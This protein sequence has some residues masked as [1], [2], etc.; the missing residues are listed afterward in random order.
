[1]IQN[2]AMRRKL[3]SSG[4]MIRAT[5]SPL[6]RSHPHSGTMAG[7]PGISLLKERAHEA[8]RMKDEQLKVLQQQ[9]RKLLGT[10]TDMEEEVADAKHKLAE[11]ETSALKVQDENLQ[12]RTSVQRAEEHGRLEAEKHFQQEVEASQHQLRV[13]AE[14]N[15]E[16]LRLLEAEE[17][18]STTTRTELTEYKHRYKEAVNELSHVRGELDEEIT[19]LKEATKAAQQRERELLAEMESKDMRARG[20]RM[21]IASLEDKLVKVSTSNVELN[22]RLLDQQRETSEKEEFMQTG[23][24]DALIDLRN[25]LNATTTELEIEKRDKSKLKIEVL[26]QADQLKEMAEKVFQLI[27]RLQAA[28]SAKEPA[29]QA[30]V[31]VGLQLRETKERILRLETERAEADKQARRFGEELRRAKNKSNENVK[32]LTEVTK[33]H[34]SEKELRLREARGRQE[35]QEARKALA[36]RVSYL[37][38]KAALDDE[39]R[40]NARVDVKKLE[41]QLHA[42][43]KKNETITAQ[44]RRLNEAN[45]VLT[46]SMRIKGDA[47]EKMQVESTMRNWSNQDKVNKRVNADKKSIAKKGKFGSR[48]NK[49]GAGGGGGGSGGGGGGGGGGGN[50]SMGSVEIAGKGSSLSRGSGYTIIKQL[51][52]GR[53]KGMPGLRASS[54]DDERATVLLK[55]LQINEFFRYIGRRPSEKAMDLCAEKMAQVVGTL[56]MSE[57]IAA[58]RA[59]RAENIMDRLR[60]ELDMLR[61]K[62][63]DQ[64]DRLFSE[65]EAK[66]SALIKYLHSVISGSGHQNGS[67]HDQEAYRQSQLSQQSATR[68]RL[69]GGTGFLD[70]MNS[71]S[72]NLSHFNSSSSSADPSLTNPS[73]GTMSVRPP[74]VTV[75]LGN[76]GIGDEEMH[77][78]VAVLSSKDRADLL[79]LKNNSIGDVGARGL[80]S[81]LRS[82]KVLCEVD[83]RENFIGATGVRILAEAL[84]HNKRVRHV[85]VHGNGRIEALGTVTE[86]GDSVLDMS[87]DDEDDVVIDTVIVV[88]VG[89]QKE[90]HSGGGGGGGGSKT[91]TSGGGT[92]LV[93]APLPPRS[94]LTSGGSSLDGGGGGGGG[95]GVGG[96]GQRPKYYTHRQQKEKLD[97]IDADRAM[98]NGKHALDTPLQN[99]IRAL[100]HD[101]GPAA[102]GTPSSDAVAEIN[103]IGEAEKWSQR[104][105]LQ[106][107]QNGLNHVPEDWI[108]TE[109]APAAYAS[110][111][112]R[113]IRA[114]EERLAIADMGEDG[115]SEPMPASE[116]VDHLTN[117]SSSS[118]HGGVRK[119]GQSER[120]SKSKSKHKTRGGAGEKGDKKQRPPLSGFMDSSSSLRSSMGSSMEMQRAKSAVPTSR[121]QHQR[122]LKSPGGPMPS[123]AWKGNRG[124]S[125]L[126]SALDQK[127]RGQSI[128][129]NASRQSNMARAAAVAQQQERNRP[130]TANSPVVG[131][132]MSARR[133]G[134]ARIL[135]NQQAANEKKEGDQLHQ[136]RIARRETMMR[137][138]SESKRGG[139]GGG[140]GG[141]HKHK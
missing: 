40:A 1:M 135:S 107:S 30:L 79:D 114:L 113:R 60:G 76:S 55:K 91:S 137:G 14:Q 4:K 11:V 23:V 69:D 85:F 37:M 34:R 17:N 134:A 105:K 39:S 81:L 46:E 97:E 33:L 84:E 31:T 124:P 49:N 86:N 125:L 22:S 66:R 139:G 138:E 140:G 48:A 116:V 80:A 41:G 106:E 20:L 47:L 8:V 90:K 99:K 111:L 15:T 117:S 5:P 51:P 59:R 43:M 65:E 100:E 28:E 36:G 112:T 57:A 58:A 29:E 45:K 2:H 136:G 44:L 38:N 61:R 122:Q 130:A 129:Q 89:N 42:S 95:G 62:A 56:R 19:T 7:S 68:E 101:L 127:E 75:R 120:K 104:A 21:N 94:L 110:P 87:D 3:A 63:Q 128:N 109:T 118:N 67:E 82:S 96:E 9:N 123:P 18:R 131:R 133:A 126:G 132:S 93:L 53:E 6:R 16:L 54:K 70:E 77:A 78:L 52:R 121:A 119:S 103:A 73:L 64:G 50:E 27:D 24:D 10:I 71:S 72:S 32:K 108:G 74:P 98:S 102:N 115:V 12:L 141:K 83:L 92:P 13:M 35:Q 88:N 26:E 25:H